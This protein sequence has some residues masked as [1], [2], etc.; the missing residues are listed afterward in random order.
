LD[1]YNIGLLFK[2]H[3]T[4][5]SWACF[6]VCTKQIFINLKKNPSYFLEIS[7]LHELCHAIDITKYYKYYSSYRRIYF[8]NI[9]YTINELEAHVGH[10]MKILKDHV[11]FPFGAYEHSQRYAKKWCENYESERYRKRGKEIADEIIPYLNQT[12][13]IYL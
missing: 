10:A 1:K 6:D 8:D 7:F 9:P 12:K 5:S 13:I 4:V 11:F 3:P 2:P